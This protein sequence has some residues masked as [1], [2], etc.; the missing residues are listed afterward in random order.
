VIS[1]GYWTTDFW[2]CRLRARGAKD[3]RSAKLAPIIGSAFQD[4]C[5]VHRDPARL[6]GP[7]PAAGRPAYHQRDI[8]ANTG[9]HSYDEVLPL[10][11]VRYFGPGL[12]GSALPP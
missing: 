3:L 10:M 4:G 6:A 1:F 9:G 11:M 12:L 7:G 5:A 8:A 2:W